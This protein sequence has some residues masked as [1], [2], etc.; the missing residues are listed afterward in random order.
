[1]LIDKKKEIE[2]FRQTEERPPSYLI[3]ILFKSLPSH[4][5]FNFVEIEKRELIKHDI[6]GKYDKASVTLNDLL[7]QKEARY[8]SKSQVQTFHTGY[9]RANNQLCG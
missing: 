3:K 2:T 6:S 5:G 1:M 7:S 4:L 9:N 8:I